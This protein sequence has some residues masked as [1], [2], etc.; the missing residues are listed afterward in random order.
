LSAASTLEEMSIV[1]Q[2][3]AVLQAVPGMALEDD[4]DPE[5]SQM[6]RLAALMP[7]DETQLLY[8]ICL[9]GI[10]ELGLA[11]DEYAALTM[12]LLRLLAFKPAHGASTPAEK[13]TLKT[14]LATPERDSPPPHSAPAA[15]VEPVVPVAPVTSVATPS[16]DEVAETYVQNRPVAPVSIGQMAPENEAKQVLPE[17]Q[18]L[19]VRELSDHPVVSKSL[20]SNHAVAQVEPEQVA[21]N[22]EA[23][24]VRVQADSP[25]DVAAASTPHSVD[26]TPE[27]DFWHATVQALIAAEAINAMARELALQ[28]QLVARDIDEWMLR[29]ERESLNQS[30]SRDRLSAA[31]VAAG[32]SVR[33]AIEVGRVT[34]SPAKRNAATAA[35][36]QLGAEKIVFDDPFVQS[37]MREFAAKI[38]P[39]SIK[40]IR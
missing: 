1:L 14:P 11:P 4:T 34:D 9:H 22:V 36:A 7:M 37:M 13:K 21:T 26:A 16:V 23:F 10:G 5:Q 29:V 28:S 20:E 32:H 2:R 27:G 18:R 33:L 15:R 35:Q 12:V 31:L 8:S 17:G 24:Q 25:R 19:A 30:G 39:G 38:V 6:Q 40:P 3:M